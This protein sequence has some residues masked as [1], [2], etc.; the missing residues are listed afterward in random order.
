MWM[1]VL[2]MRSLRRRPGRAT[3]GV[4]VDVSEESVFPVGFHQGQWMCIITKVS[5]AK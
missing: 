4:S 3:D 5:C 2:D 1:P